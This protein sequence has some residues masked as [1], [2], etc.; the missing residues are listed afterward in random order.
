MAGKFVQLLDPSRNKRIPDELTAG[1]RHTGSR[2]IRRE[3]GPSRGVTGQLHQA[4]PPDPKPV[5]AN[6]MPMIDDLVQTVVTQSSGRR[7]GR[8][9]ANTTDH[10]N[11]LPIELAPNQASV[12]KHKLLVSNLT[13]GPRISPTLPG[14]DDLDAIVLVIWITTRDNDRVSTILAAGD[15]AL[16]GRMH[17]FPRELSPIRELTALGIPGNGPVRTTYRHKKSIESPSH[18]PIVSPSL[19][20]GSPRTNTRPLTRPQRCNT[21]RDHTNTGH[22]FVAQRGTQPAHAPARAGSSTAGRHTP[23]PIPD[24]CSTTV[25]HR[26][27][28]TNGPPDHEHPGHAHPDR[29]GSEPTAPRVCGGQ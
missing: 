12:T 19:A 9:A 18:T 10:P 25:T 6:I 28:R 13:P 3:S 14:V 27:A 8:I 5:S 1:T 24:Q 15:S 21:Q 22:S 11:R 4:K 17:P 26:T 2:T 29:A 7:V 16:R 20:S 23:A